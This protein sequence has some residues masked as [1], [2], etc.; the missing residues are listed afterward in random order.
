[1]GILKSDATRVASAAGFAFVFALQISTSWAQSDFESQSTEAPSVLAESSPAISTIPVAETENPAP[2]ASDTRDSEEPRRIDEIMVTATKREK[3]LREIPASISA[4][5]GESLEDKGQ[6]NLSDYIQ[7]TP[8]VTV[9]HSYPGLSRF[10]IRGI[11]TETVPLA[12]LPSPVGFFI[13]DT[14]FT[15]P[16]LASV[17]PDLSAFDLA[18][19]QVLKGP[20]GTLFGGAALSGAVRYELN[21]PEQAIWKLRGFAQTTQPEGG[22]RAVSSG[23]AMNI[24]VL[25]EQN[26]ALRL[27]YIQREYPGVLDNGLTGEQN[28]ERAKGIQ[29]RAIALWE[30]GDWKI[31][32]THFTQEFNAKD[33]LGSVVTT[34]DGTRTNDY[35]VTKSPA[36]NEIKLG[37][38]EL[39]YEF[40]SMRLVSLSSMLEKK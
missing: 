15:D 1:M 27:T 30:P 10:T 31:K 39:G 28:V 13:G 8:G 22:S 35:N 14:A 21:D 38:L 6:L 34:T 4:I 25:A 20:Q 7:K 36:Y 9:T 24:P 5:S 40:D 3:S 2:P 33:T 17:I 11:N 29:I 32:A 19:V 23:L 16:Y 18:G 26:L 37:S 12:A